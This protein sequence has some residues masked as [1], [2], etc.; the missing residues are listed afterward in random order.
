MFSIITVCYNA[1]ELLDGT[2]QS[3]LNQTS[4]DYEYLIIDGGSTDHSVDVIN[5][6]RNRINVFISE[7][8]KGIYDA[9]NKGLQAARGEFVWFINAGDRI[10]DDNVL[11]RLEEL[12]L[13]DVDVAYG[14]VMLVDN[15]RKHIG[16]RSEITVHKLPA[17]LR[18]ADM[19]RGMIVCHQGFITRR[20]LCE[21]FID[22]NLS[23]DIDWVIRILAKKPRVLNVGMIL[24]EYLM[25][26]V[27]KQK[28]YQ[29]LYDRWLILRHHFGFFSATSQH[30]FILF[31]A[32]IH[33]VFHSG[34]TH[35]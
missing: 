20:A 4:T 31:R 7:K 8:D 34:N 11:T 29:S 28:W 27:S 24:A 2:I 12:D 33:R 3:V 25:G 19:K 14:E 30:I 6:Y 9:M 32:A 23:A 18:W 1:A 10:M 5:K 17:Q 21:H 26:G 13:S 35:Y 16:T 15:T 22:E